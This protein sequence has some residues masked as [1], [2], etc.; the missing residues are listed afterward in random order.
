MYGYTT[1]RNR[2]I[3]GLHVGD[4]QDALAELRGPR[5]HSV[6]VLAAE[7]HQPAGANPPG[8]WCLPLND[9]EEPM[10]PKLLKR[11]RAMVSDLADVVAFGSS[12]LVTCAMGLNRSGLVAALA[13]R[14][15]GY[16]AEEAIQLV[17]DARGPLAL[18]NEQF[19]ALIA[20]RREG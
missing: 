6:L 16:S 18:R 9:D 1:Q 12:V 17:R 7:E 5:A 13:L 11:M 8:T 14:E 19:L 2:V 15:L 4:Y 3:P 20:E 10:S